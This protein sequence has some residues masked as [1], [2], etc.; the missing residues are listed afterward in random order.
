M[1][2][3]RRRSI[4]IWRNL[5]NEILDDEIRDRQSVVLDYL[6]HKRECLTERAR[7]DKGEVEVEI[8]RYNGHGFVREMELSKPR[9][10]DDG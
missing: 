9:K 5:P 7:G 10:K 6:D 3:G 8:E 4:A 1:K 2:R